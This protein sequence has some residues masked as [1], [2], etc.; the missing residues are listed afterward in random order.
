MSPCIP[1]HKV[2]N[3]VPRVSIISESAVSI[4]V[5]CLPC[6]SRYTA[7]RI[8]NCSKS[9]SFITVAAMQK[10][11]RATHPSYRL[12]LKYPLPFSVRYFQRVTQ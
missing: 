5:L 6:S 2:A 1:H 7:V 3:N 9:T 8:N 10:Y 11:D 4:T 12:K